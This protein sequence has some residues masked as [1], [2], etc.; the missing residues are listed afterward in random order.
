MSKSLWSRSV[1]NS[2][3]N[4]VAGSQRI[5]RRRNSLRTNWKNGVPVEALE[6]RVAATGWRAVR[7]RT[8]GLRG[9]DG[10]S[11]VRR[12][13]L[14]VRCGRRRVPGRHRRE[15]SSYLLIEHVA[16][17]RHA[18]PAGD[19]RHADQHIF[20]SLPPERD[21]CGA[22]LLGECCVDAVATGEELCRGREHCGTVERGVGFLLGADGGRHARNVA[23][24]GHRA[25]AAVTVI[26]M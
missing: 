7:R 18:R 1:W 15:E 4:R 14:D 23:R 17:A 26:S 10:R 25:R 9:R 11:C 13:G 22:G 6:Q 20:A 12:D 24:P 21:K 2:L 19:L 3:F 16:G 8:D 5:S